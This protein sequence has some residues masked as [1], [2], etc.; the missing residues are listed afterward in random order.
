MDEI[1]GFWGFGFLTVQGKYVEI[2]GKKIGID[3]GIVLGPPRFKNW[4]WVLCGI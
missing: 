3:F 4:P 2:F 1:K